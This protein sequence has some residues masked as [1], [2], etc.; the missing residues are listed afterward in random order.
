MRRGQGLVLAAALAL[1]L[2]AR[3]EEQPEGRGTWWGAPSL[4]K[5]WNPNLPQSEALRV[6][7]P[8]T[9]DEKVQEV[10]LKEAIGLALEN[11]P[12]IAARRLEPLR[13]GTGVLQ[14]QAQFDP[15]LA[16]EVESHSETTP[17]TSSLSQTSVNNIDDRFA[18]FHLLKT[19]RTGTRMSVD[20]L[21]ERLDNNATYVDLRPQYTPNLNLSVVQ[22]LLRGFGWDFTYLVVR[23]AEQTAD[24]AAYQ[25]EANLADFVTLV[26]EAYWNV[27]RAREQLE[28]QRESKALADRT[29][30]ENEARVKVGLFAPIAVL[31]AQADAKSREEQVIIALNDL[32]VARQRLAQLVFYRPDGTFVPRTLEPIQEPAAEDIDVNVDRA[33][34]VALAD[35]PE[36]H[37]SA[38][39]IRARQLNERIAENGLLP[40]VDLVGSYGVNGTSGGSE[41]TTS[42][43]DIPSPFESCVSIP[44]TTNTVLPGATRFRCTRPASGFRGTRGDA[45]DRLT[46]NDFRSYSFGVQVQIPLSNALARSEYA[47]RRIERDQAELD[48]RELLSTV[49]LQVR[50]NAADLISARQRIDTTR[51]ARELAEENLRNQEKRHEVGMATTKDLLDFQTRLTTARASEVQANVDYQNALARWLRAQ[52]HLLSAYQIV[53]EQPGRRSTPWFARF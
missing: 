28:V 50:Q 34:D 1:A 21:N 39:T 8:V 13:Q 49:T 47:A 38:R 24:A 42:I 15:A 43:T 23:V 26:I 19:F 37:A 36:I 22:P 29:V 10:T 53:I 27:V 33:L 48:H 18:N 51:V 44:G 35:R 45:Y 3:A 4:P 32:A 2:G 41:T 46:T 40:R 14:A 12:G 20:S 16:S 25:Y 30:T 9:R 6:P 11:N 17:N 52:G 7:V 5:Q 31:E